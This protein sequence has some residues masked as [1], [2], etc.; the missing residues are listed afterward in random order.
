[1]LV[2][3][4]LLNLGTV[5]CTL[6]RSRTTKTKRL[7]LAAKAVSLLI[8]LL[9]GKPTVLLPAPV[10]PFGLRPAIICGSA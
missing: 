3:M 1:M 6:S 4:V 9:L 5:G 2:R 7:T 8:G 10:V